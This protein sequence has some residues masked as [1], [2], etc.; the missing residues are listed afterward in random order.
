MDAEEYQ[1]AVVNMFERRCHDRIGHASS[2][3]CSEAGELIAL[4][5]KT[6]VMGGE[7]DPLSALDECGD[8]LYFL[9][10]ALDAAGFTLE[11]A[12]RVNYLKMSRRKAF[13]KDKP[14][15]RRLLE[16]AVGWR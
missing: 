1:D 9:T 8:A 15:E 3:L 6:L 7:V 16:E 11:D 14:A 2:G 10:L 12:M 4:H 5:R 13:G